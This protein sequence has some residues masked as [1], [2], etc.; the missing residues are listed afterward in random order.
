RALIDRLI[1]QLREHGRPPSPLWVEALSAVPRDRFV[2]QVAWA[3]PDQPG[4]RGYRIDAAADP[5][6]WWQTVYSDASLIIQADDG[7]GDPPAGQ[8]APS[9]SVSAP[10]VVF[11]FLDLLDVRPGDRVLDV[12]TGSGWTAA[13]L[14]WRAGDGNVTSI[15]IDP[16]V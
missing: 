6:G 1:D 9:S 11:A 8:G 14:S 12:G 10:G 16:E 15:E 13:L 5:T 7:A 2:P 3:A 4:Q